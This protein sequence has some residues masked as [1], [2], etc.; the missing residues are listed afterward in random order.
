MAVE[1]ILRG[2]DV[3][4]R[5]FQVKDSAGTL[6]NIAD[7]LDYNIYVYS[8]ED[9]EK[10]HQLTFRK[11]PVGDDK[12]IVI[13]DTTTIGFIVDRNYTKTAPLGNLYAEIEVQL[14]ASSNYVSSKQNTGND[15]YV[16]CEII[17]SSNP[18]ALI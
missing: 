6:I 1:K 3:T 14:T 10:V 13:V 4:M 7:I 18:E 2:T 15:D 9:N 16:V 8:I 5:T 11:T 17:E 12:S